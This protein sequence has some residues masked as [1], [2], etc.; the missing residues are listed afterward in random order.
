MSLDAKK[1][2]L[3]LVLPLIITVNVKATADY[4]DQHGLFVITIP[5]GWIYQAQESDSRLLVFYGPQQD[6]LLYIEYFFGIEHDS[7]LEFAHTVLKHF[8]AE[9]GLPDFTVLSELESRDLTGIPAE[10]IVYSYSGR[11]KRMEHRLFVINRQ[12]G[13][14]ITYSDSFEAYDTNRDQ[15]N[16]V[17]DRWSWTEVNIQ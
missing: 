11:K 7:A 16:Y 2:L 4:V 12:W 1:W 13:L 6:Q 9:Y 5:P 3:S 15:F 17:L 10:E 8:D 14:T